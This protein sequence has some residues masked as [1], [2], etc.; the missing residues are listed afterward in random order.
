M[1][2]EIRKIAL[3]AVFSALVV[4]MILLGTFIDVLDITAAAISCLVVYIVQ[5]EAQGK[6]PF[7][8]YLTSSVLSL[9]FIPLSTATLYFIGFFGYYPI[10]KLL[11]I[12]KNKKVRKLICAFIF[13]VA[14]I[15]L[16]LM[17]KAVFALQN[18]P[19]GMYIAL[20]ITVNVFFLCFD[21]LHD[22]FAFIYFRKL[23]NKIKFIK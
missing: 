8:V 21:Y 10:I 17:F 6:Y 1:K 16:F 3:S 13:N 14:T 20:L 2:T 7:L 22:V 12:K 5:L 18:E 23:R 9:I 11:L 15:I 19:L 4:V